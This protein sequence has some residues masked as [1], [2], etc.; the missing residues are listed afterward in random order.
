M[1]TGWRDFRPPT[2]RFY[3]ADPPTCGYAVVLW[4]GSKECLPGDPVDPLGCWSSVVSRHQLVAA[5]F[6]LAA[7]MGFR[8]RQ[9]FAARAVLAVERRFVE[10]SVAVGL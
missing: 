3:C 6:A 2:L 5:R 4:G 7:T 9:A 10:E 8:G 1:V